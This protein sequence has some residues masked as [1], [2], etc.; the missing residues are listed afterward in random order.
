MATKLIYVRR[1]SE[2]GDDYSLDTQTEACERYA[3]LR[4]LA[5]DVMVLREN[6]TGT[7][8]LREREVGAE[9]WRLLQER[10]A[11]TLI[12]YSIDRLSRAKLRHAL[13]LIDDLLD[14]GVH[15]HAIDVGEITNT[16][17]IGLIIRSWQAG[18]E[19]RKIVER[20]MRGKLGKAQAGKWPG[21]Y[22]P[23]FGYHK[24]GQGK[25]ARLVIEPAEAETVT[26]IYQW[27]VG[28]GERVGIRGIIDRLHAR[29]ISSPLDKPV[30]GTKSVRRILTS[31]TYRGVIVYRGIDIALPELR[32]VSDEVW[33]AAQSQRETNQRQSTRNRK[34][35]YLLAGYLYCSECGS[36]MYGV[37]QKAR[38]GYY[39]YLYRCAQIQ[40]PPS[41]RT[42]SV[43]R[44]SVPR[45]DALI[46][47]FVCERIEPGRLQA[48]LAALDRQDQTTDHSAELGR[49]DLDIKRLSGQ[50][51][52]LLRSARDDD[53]PEVKKTFETELD[54]IRADITK[55]TDK[56]QALRLDEQA[57]STR[58]A[59]R[60][61][62][63]ERLAD[64]RDKVDT[65]DFE[66]KRDTLDIVGLRVTLGYIDGR[67]SVTIHS[68][69]ASE[70]TLIIPSTWKKR[71]EES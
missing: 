8:H 48:G 56:R 25:N 20:L 45:V 37:K 9:A 18:E 33:Q 29:G 52:T 42:C 43:L 68:A 65:A 13:T 38:P 47:D 26:Q 10:K 61:T 34:H 17:D 32:L 31:P 3:A 67:K 62:L 4:G 35:D 44:A 71:R 2:T 23:P 54:R 55:A 64:V 21:E 58:Q 69:I 5:G 27:Y 11:D 36:R 59:K 53:A 15:L 16:D 7:L 46:W 12:V 39:T 30:W 66:F 60:A 6:F 40:K 28:Q 24:V 14:L 70:E 63:I 50:L 57:Q 51:R 22:R 1:S 19:R 49:I 41:L